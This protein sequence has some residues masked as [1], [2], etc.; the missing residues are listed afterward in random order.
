MLGETGTTGKYYAPPEAEGVWKLSPLSV[1][2]CLKRICEAYLDIEAARQSGM[3]LPLPGQNLL[4]I[5]WTTIIQ[6]AMKA[7]L[8]GDGENLRTCARSILH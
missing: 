4:R 6:E 3:R 1:T 5:S 2:P 8:C 7:L